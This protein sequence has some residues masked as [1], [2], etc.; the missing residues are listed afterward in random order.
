MNLNNVVTH[1]VASEKKG[2]KASSLMYSRSHSDVLDACVI[3]MIS[4]ILRL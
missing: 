1:A 4:C 2:N 3:L